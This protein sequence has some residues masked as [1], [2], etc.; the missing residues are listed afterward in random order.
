MIRCVPWKLPALKD[1]ATDIIPCVF[2]V[3]YDATQ[4][5]LSKVKSQI[6]DY[7][8][9]NGYSAWSSAVAQTDGHHML[10]KERKPISRAYCK[11]IELIETCVLSEPKSSLHLC[12]APGQKRNF[13]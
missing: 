3:P 5:S 1:D 12:E 10:G 13:I 2:E 7:K 9:R 8:L 4:E 11:L 6:G